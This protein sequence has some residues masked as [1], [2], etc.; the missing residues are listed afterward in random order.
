MICLLQ[1][2]SF[3]SVTVNQNCIGQIEQGLVVLCGFKPDDSAEKLEKMAQR[4]LKYRAFSD[5]NGKMNLN[6]QQVDGGLLLV[7]QF[8]LAADTKSGLRPS[9]STSAAPDIAKQ[10]FNDFISICEKHYTKVQT[11]EFGADMQV[12]IHNDGPVT[13]WLEN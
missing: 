10:W 8:T 4:I 6:V 3:G 13:F 1:R 12:Q 7:P 11:G 5:D 9:F 2:V